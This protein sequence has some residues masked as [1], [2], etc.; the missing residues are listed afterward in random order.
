MCSSDMCLVARSV[1][2]IAVLA[3]QNVKRGIDMTYDLRPDMETLSGKE[4]LSEGEN[5]SYW[6][7]LSDRG[8]LRW[9]E[10]VSVE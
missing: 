3:S 4:K 8:K 1:I 10:I 6:K 2:G 7:K 5:M 9:L